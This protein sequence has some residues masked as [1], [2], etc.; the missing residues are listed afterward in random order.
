MF[1]L[2]QL[3]YDLL[4]LNVFNIPMMLLLLFLYFSIS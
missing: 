3:F 2:T 1:D 4:F